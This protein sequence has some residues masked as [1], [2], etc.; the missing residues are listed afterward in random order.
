MR[1]IFEIYNLRIDRA[2]ALEAV[3]IVQT[4]PKNSELKFIAWCD[5]RYIQVQ[6]II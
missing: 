6:R 4:I 2:D 5:V 1:K 3:S